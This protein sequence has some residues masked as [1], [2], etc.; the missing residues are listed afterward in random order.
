[1]G[2]KTWAHGE[3]GDSADFD[4]G[5][6]QE[7]PRSWLAGMSTPDVAVEET[8]ATYV[9]HGFL[10]IDPASDVLAFVF[11]FKTEDLIETYSMKAEVYV[12]PSGAR[13]IL[14]D[15]SLSVTTAWSIPLRQ[16]HSITGL[17]TNGDMSG[18]RLRVEVFLKTTG[19]M[20]VEVRN[21]R[22]YCGTSAFSSDYLR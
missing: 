5:F 1:V 14:F 16:V 18:E 6:Y 22:I 9:A 17:A 3:E 12:P 7:Q 15:I 19:G 11:Q 13:D 4:A 20:K 2:A 10:D 8:G 21:L